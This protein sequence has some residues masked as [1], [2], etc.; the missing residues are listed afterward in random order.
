MTRFLP[1]SSPLRQSPCPERP[2]CHMD[3]PGDEG[4][5]SPLIT[6]QEKGGEAEG[7]KAAAPPL[8]TAEEM[9]FR[10]KWTFVTVVDFLMI[11]LLLVMAGI[12]ATK[13]FL[14]TPPYVNPDKYPIRGIDVS[15][16][17]GMMNFD[18]A[19]QDGISFVFIKASEG[20]GFRDENFRLNYD[21]ANAAGLKTGAYH[22]FR[23]D[24]AGV[25]QA[26]NFLKAIGDRDLDLGLA[27]DV[28]EH[29]N[30]TGV[31]QEKII[32]RLQAMIEF[33][34]LKGHRVILYSN[35]DGYYDFIE[36]NFKG[37]PLWICSFSDPPIST[38]WDFWQ[39]NHRGKVKGIRGDVD[40]NTFSGSR[41]QWYDYLS[42]HVAED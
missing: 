18:A 24:A 22:Y 35:R 15:A 13:H 36:E 17:N 33:L 30:A 34:N 6:C 9:I 19:A 29:G 10:R 32:D 8:L 21:K 5:G 42:G 40:M 11:S 26:I 2:L 25:P 4:G 27:I 38:E 12:W 16:H 20:T 31:S 41:Q 28:E 39:F 23:F 37:L 7:A 1:Y 14:E 3:T